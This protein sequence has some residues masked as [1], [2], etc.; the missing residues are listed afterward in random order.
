MLLTS[1]LPLAGCR[2]FGMSTQPHCQGSLDHIVV[3]RSS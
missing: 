3:E 2:L 1:I